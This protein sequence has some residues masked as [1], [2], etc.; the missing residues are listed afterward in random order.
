MNKKTLVLTSDRLYLRPLEEGDI[1]NIFRGLSDP[2]V[3]KYYG[4]SFGSLKATEEQMAWYADLIKNNTGIWWAICFKADDGFL[5]AAGLNDMDM[6]LGK[7]E[8]GFWLLPE[9][10]AKGIMSESVPL[11]LQHAFHEIGLQRIE[12]FVESENSDCKRLLERL[13]FDFEGTEV[14]S[15]F[16]NGVPISVDTYAKMI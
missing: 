11:V 14:D 6:A 3:I 2:K 15:E 12:A 8:L 1:G 4:V 7:A 13:E 9:N 5:G 10:W 16:K